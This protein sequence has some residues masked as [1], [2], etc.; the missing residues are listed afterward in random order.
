MRLWMTDTGRM[1]SRPQGGTTGRVQ[2]RVLQPSMASAWASGSAGRDG[3]RGTWRRPGALA[4][5]RTPTM[6]ST[7][8]SAPTENER[9]ASVSHLD[10]DGES[11]GRHAAAGRGGPAMTT[12]ILA[13]GPAATGVRQ[14][15]S[16]PAS[17]CAKPTRVRAPDCAELLEGGTLDPDLTSC[18]LLLRRP[19][20]RDTTRPAP[21][22]A[23]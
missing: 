9:L 10:V 3:A 1:V 16:S 6:S 22:L 7:S 15:R 12:A 14:P 17:T 21:T 5:A 11:L 18:A 4:S 2:R 19:R 23:P 20:H 13:M 8:A